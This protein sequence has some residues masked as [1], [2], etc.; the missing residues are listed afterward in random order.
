M[1]VVE[2]Y[3]QDLSGITGDLTRLNFGVQKH[4]FSLG[5]NL[6]GYDGTIDKVIA[7]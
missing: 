4:N 2:K 7:I 6:L 3:L 1:A 5:I